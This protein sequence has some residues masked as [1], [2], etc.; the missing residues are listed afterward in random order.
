MLRWACVLILFFLSGC[1]HTSHF[2]RVDEKIVPPDRNWIEDLRAAN[3]GKIDFSKEINSSWNESQVW[4]FSYQRA[5]FYEKTEPLK[6]CQ[7]YLILSK[8]KDFPLWDLA[9]LR[10]QLVCAQPD[11][12]F[13]ENP[14]SR[15][16]WY[17][18]LQILIREKA[19]SLTADLQDDIELL[20]E[21][22]KHETQP[23]KKEKLILEAVT[24]A[25][26]SGKQ[27]LMSSAEERLVQVFPRY[28]KNPVRKNWL[29]IA[30]DFRQ[31]RKFDQAEKFY[32]AILR[33]GDL[34]AQWSAWKGLRQINKTKQDR[35]GTLAIDKKIQAWLIKVL[36]KNKNSLWIKRWHDHK[37]MQIRQLW[38]DDQYQVAFQSLTKAKTTFKNLYPRDEIFFLMSRMQEEKA[39]SIEA[40]ESLNRSLL[41]KES[42]PGLRE[43]ALWTSAWLYYKEGKYGLTLER[44]NENLKLSIEPPSRYK[45]LFW[46]ARTQNRLSLS[47]STETYK[48]LQQEDP[49]G[50]YGLLAFYDMKIPLPALKGHIRDSLNLHARTIPEISYLSGLK[51]DWLISLEEKEV[52]EEALKNS[53]DKLKNGKTL[54]EDSWL[55]FFSAFA[56]ARLYLPLF[57]NLNK[58][59]SETR[60]QLL[61]THPELIF[62]RPYDEFVL[63]SAEKT[64]VSPWLIYSIM[65][66]ESAFDP[67]ARSLVDAMGLLQL[68]PALAQNLAKQ[69]GI[70]YKQP[71]DLF[72]PKINISLGALE[73]KNLLKHYKNNSILAVA[74]YNAN[75]KAIQGWLKTRLRPDPIEFIEEIPYEETRSYV[76]LVFRNFVFYERLNKNS[77]NLEFPKEL[78][79][80]PP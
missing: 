9:W 70:E 41:E 80:W 15:N 37:L 64:G 48:I 43:K 38:T 58:I 12:T 44:L 62:G 10:S 22:S 7:D 35:K 24:L 39:L 56:Q 4:W 79:I 63:S 73:L 11:P 60:D 74:A 28:Q 51:M 6:S 53:L 17:S 16:P 36:K 30:T 29:E 3:D 20:I 19:S 8:K 77:E 26:K 14:I 46:K 68:M 59:K 65:R 54:S 72:E 1:T 31:F 76:K 78:L 21:K 33:D 67:Q 27:E 25:K 2:N 5:L 69:N 75:S 47:D 61:K 13:A 55:K 66:Q 42:S 71:E 32:K 57:S 50:L 40:Q 49:L 34:E 52:L 18:P 23:K 45:Y